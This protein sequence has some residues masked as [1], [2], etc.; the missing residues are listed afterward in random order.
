MSMTIVAMGPSRVPAGTATRADATGADDGFATVFGNVL[1]GAAA[2]PPG[3]GS[4]AP[5]TEAP[6]VA[7]QP[8]EAQPAT[9]QPGE[10]QP[11]TA[12]PATTAPAAPKR[13]GPAHERD[14]DTG[15]SAE[16]VP[17]GIA[18]VPV[19]A[20]Q[21]QAVPVETATAGEAPGPAVQA[22]DA[23]APAKPADRPQATELSTS[24][25]PNGVEPGTP[26]KA[27]PARHHAGE[28]TATGAAPAPAPV[29]PNATPTV[30]PTAPTD[31]ATPTAPA[32]PASPADQLAMRLV[33]LR[34]G[35]DG[36][37]R[38]TV[39]LNPVDLG[40]VSVLAEIRGTDIH[41]QLAGAT[42]AGRQALQAALPLLR[43]ELQD[44]GFGSC[45]MDVQQDTPQG[46][47]QEQQPTSRYGQPDRRGD[48][49]S[50]QAK[51]EPLYQQPKSTRTGLDLHV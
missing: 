35:P 44:A 36:I 21:Q 30:A 37:H 38:L 18:A 45:A 9:G 42:E 47:R 1:N 32:A 22:V 33:P 7:G 19:P 40:P 27:T 13:R 39:H 3:P 51:R 26:A 11:A 50:G 48:S 28:A 25:I 15:P 16:V 34:K 2:S 41:L 23:T 5:A 17:P 49:E 20:V 24:D 4:P 12:P 8:G 6:V 14:A 31:A 43:K 29:P 46:Q 10:A